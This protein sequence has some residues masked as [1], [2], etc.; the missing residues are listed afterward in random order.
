MILQRTIQKKVSIVGVGLHSGNAVEM[1]ILP[2]KAGSGI[3]FRRIDLDPVVEIKVGARLVTDTMLCTVIEKDGVK[4][5]TIEHIMSALSGF[6][7]DNVIV[8]LSSPE[9]P[10]VDGSSAPFVYLLQ[11]AGVLEQ[12]LAKKFLIIKK[13]VVVTD[14]DKIAR[15]LPYSQGF[16]LD[17]AIDF[18][19]PAIKKSNPHISF[20][21]NKKNY[22]Q[23]ISRART[24]GFLGDIEFLR[25]NNLALGGSLDNAVVLDKY[26]VLND[27]GLRYKDEFVRHKVLDAI[28]D[29]YL[30][31]YSI[32]GNYIGYKSG[33]DLNNK[34]YI[35]LLAD[36]D[37][38]EIK[39]LDKDEVLFDK[40]YSE[41]NLS[42]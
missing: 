35:A 3:R 8:E 4:V 41:I 26:R 28:G 38:Y 42:F 11:Q 32:L 15:L 6:G 31:G 33:H 16:K 21:L 34:L 7:I 36:K 39:E 30:E 18:T 14:G 10:I 25:Q 40:T 19:H 24:F 5:A 17:F 29:L 37:A 20:L 2:A 1:N 22:I 9:V 23:E 13:E 12:D 27:K